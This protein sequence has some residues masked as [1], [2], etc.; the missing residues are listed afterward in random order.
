M[1]PVYEGKER[2]ARDL[3]LAR[4]AAAP[5]ALFCPRPLARQTPAAAPGPGR[6][7]S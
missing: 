1:A 5:A 7:G 3:L 2:P 6:G 4:P